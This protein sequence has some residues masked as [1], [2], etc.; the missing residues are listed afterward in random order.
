MYT[1]RRAGESDDAALLE[2]YSQSFGK[3]FSPTWWEW[4]RHNP[5]GPN[6]TYVVE[7]RD[8][9]AAAYS[10]LP[11]WLKLGQETIKASL[12]NNACTSP[13]YQGK[14]LFVRLGEY[15]LEDDGKAGAV[16]S[17]GMPNLKALPGH[18]KVGWQVECSLP[19]LVL[20]HPQAQPNECSPVDRFEAEV[21]TLLRE[22]QHASTFAVLKSH[23]WLNWRLVDHPERFYHRF[24]LRQKQRLVGL[25]VVKHFDRAG[26]RMS[27]IVDLQ[28]VDEAALEQLLRAAMSCADGRD[29][30]NLWTNDKDPYR[31]SIMSLGFEERASDDRLIIHSNRGSAVKVS[32]GPLCFSLSDND[33]Y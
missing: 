10:V 19:F 31:A 25:V 27:H 5:V 16:V 32:E 17:L 3:S 30:L 9:L 28:V 18:L 11:L 23:L 24:V 22:T 2:L 33:V 13:A 4:Y 29:E 8:G 26:V 6:R 12:A 1:L 21:D 7:G 15:A 20:H 14:G